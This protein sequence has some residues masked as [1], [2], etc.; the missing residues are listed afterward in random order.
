MRRRPRELPGPTPLTHT[1]ARCTPSHDSARMQGSGRL[2][3]ALL[4][5]IALSGWLGLSL[6]LLV[7][8]RSAE[9]GGRGAVLGILEALCY[10]TVL[11]NV[12]IT[13]IATAASARANRPRLLLARGTRAAAAVYIAVVGIIYSLLRR[14]LWSPSGLHR[15]ADLILHDLQPLLYILWWSCFAPRGGLGW[16]QPLRWLALP[17]RLSGVLPAARRR[18]RA[19]PLSIRGRRSARS[20]GRRAQRAAVARALL[21]NGPRRGRDRSGGSAARA[22]LSDGRN[23]LL[24]QA[25]RACPDAPAP[26]PFSPPP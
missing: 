9:R 23:P 18:Q 25:A 8:A 7:A 13:A 11:T 12:L 1:I 26:R 10:F 20:V 19:L 5:L 16:L 24:S 21:G 6:Q 22:S 17:A 3:R 15:A 14:A 4:L 2:G